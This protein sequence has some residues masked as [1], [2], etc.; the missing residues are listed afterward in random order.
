M[1]LNLF[2]GGLSKRLAP[3]L[4]DVSQG[5]EVEN[6][7]LTS[8]LLTPDNKDLIL[9]SDYLNSIYYFNGNWITSDGIRTYVEYNNKLYYTNGNE[10]KKSSDGI[11]FYNLG[12]QAPTAEIEIAG[13]GLKQLNYGYL[14]GLYKTNPA[15]AKVFTGDV[16]GSFTYTQSAGSANIASIKAIA[17]KVARSSFTDDYL[18]FKKG[19]TF[20]NDINTNFENKEIN[21]CQAFLTLPYD[22][23]STAFGISF[24]S[25]DFSNKAISYA[26]DITSA[27]ISNQGLFKGTSLLLRDGDNYLQIQGQVYNFNGPQIDVD[28]FSSVVLFPTNKIDFNF[29]LPF[30]F[31]SRIRSGFGFNAYW[32]QEYVSQ[33]LNLNSVTPMLLDSASTDTFNL[34]TQDNLNKILDI[35]ENNQWVCV[36][37]NKSTLAEE[38]EIIPYL[39]LMDSNNSFF[40]MRLIKDALPLDISN[41]DVK[42]YAGTDDNAPEIAMTNGSGITS[43]DDMKKEGFYWLNFKFTGRTLAD[44]IKISDV[45]YLCYTY[46]NMNDGTE[47]IPSPYKYISDFWASLTLKIKTSPDP[48]VT[49]IRLWGVVK[50][51]TTPT[52]LSTV[53]NDPSSEFVDVSTDFTSTTS[54]TLNSYTNYPPEAG[55]RFLTEYQA[56]FFAAKAEYLYYSSIGDP[57]YWSP[58]NFFQLE[59][60]IT[61]IG[62]TANGLLVF[63]KH[64]THLITGTSSS[65]FVKYILDNSTGCIAHNT[66]QNVQGSLI[67]LSDDGIMT[68][69]GGVPSNLSRS[70]LGDLEYD[71][72]YDSAYHN[73]V[74]YL[75]T[76]RNTIVFDTR[77]GQVYKYISDVYLGLLRNKTFDL[78]Y[79]VNRKNELVQI[80]GDTSSY[81][82]LK[83]KSPKLPSGSLS[84]AKIYKTLYVNSTG[85]LNLNIYID[86]I[87]L[88]TTELT[89]GVEQI[90]VPQDEMRGYYLQVEVTGTGTLYEIEF[91]AMDRQ[92]GR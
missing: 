53:V 16:I 12:I 82:T 11:V 45:Y 84:K 39:P 33:D 79:G 23:T 3:H 42:L 87:L 10:A 30:N 8:G 70:V 85:D 35:F 21:T 64:K 36:Y 76:N 28:C 59:S 90:R 19:E 20:K 41:Y 1:Q 25:E 48:Q 56:I 4:I 37:K 51:F 55:V 67:W 6:V 46:Y 57:N 58:L 32:G 69:N 49:H 14:E 24:I 9:A 43:T 71:T 29:Y 17:E 47:S 7:N 18:L 83:Y 63:T 74:Y 5:T 92:N 15:K 77:F 22:D 68:S 91:V 2:N 40:G 78:L 54:E 27:T 73:D 80:C 38:S 60:E 75:A 62:S 34:V 61:G 31:T 50:N 52:L 72:I 86:D 13:R 88:T 44:T 26:I 89:G 81:K 65:N 66:I